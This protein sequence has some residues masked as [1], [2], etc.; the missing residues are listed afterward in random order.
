MKNTRG[1]S[2]SRYTLLALVL[3]GLGQSLLCTITFDPAIDLDKKSFTYEANYTARAY[4]LTQIAKIISNTSLSQDRQQK[5]WT[6]LKEIFKQP[7]TFIPTHD[8]FTDTDEHFDYNNP[9]RYLTRINIQLPNE[10]ANNGI[11]WCS[12]PSLSNVM[13]VETTLKQLNALNTTFPPDST[14]AIVHTTFGPGQGAQLYLLIKGM[15]ILGYQNI[16]IQM[17]EPAQPPTD[18]IQ[19]LLSAD[20]NKKVT[21]IH[22]PDVYSLKAEDTT[23]KSH[24]FD[25]IDLPT[26]YESSIEQNYTPSQLVT[27][28]QLAENIQ[29][30]D[31]ESADIYK[32]LEGDGT[33]QNYLVAE[34]NLT[35]EDASADAIASRARV[36]NA[37]SSLSKNNKFNETL[38][39]LTEENFNKLFTSEYEKISFARIFDTI[40]TLQ[41]HQENTKS[42]TVSALYD[43]FCCVTLINEQ[44]GYDL[45]HARINNTLSGKDLF[46]EIPSEEDEE[47]PEPTLL[48][49]AQLEELKKLTRTAF[50]N[51]KSKSQTQVTQSVIETFEK[52]IQKHEPQS[53]L[54]V[55]LHRSIYGEYSYLV[56]QNKISNNAI[57]FES[58]NQ[59]IHYSQG[60]FY[61]TQELYDD[62][63]KIL[64]DFE[65]PADF[66]TQAIN[67]LTNMLQLLKLKMLRLMQTL[68][69]E[70]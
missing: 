34:Y 58:N 54:S 42:D 44:N 57:V 63:S 20:E 1:H 47:E 61:P 46:F 25:I 3:I 10:P 52:F 37:L 27:I 15:L 49:A 66:A 48:S 65:I 5:F 21:L 70:I 29:L 69:S 68:A 33:N 14:P 35:D 32:L 8:D 7:Y 43:L 24:S 30:N 23:K 2:L 6:F 28:Q 19:A 17:I 4:E 62:F 60:S 22:F 67:Q 38:K 55:Q 36:L 56:E 18:K 9:N 16:T 50:I 12:C 53:T 13:R 64:P 41:I 26:D 45:I 51:N 31:E 59:K 40:T 39:N 11:A